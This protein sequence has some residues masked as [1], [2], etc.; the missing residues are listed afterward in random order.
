MNAWLSLFKKDFRIIAPW[1]LTGLL[2]ILSIDLIALLMVADL[3]T[4][5]ILSAV[6]IFFHILY[7][8][9]FLIGSLEREGKQMHL[10]LHSPRPAWQLL[11]SKVL[12]ALTAK[13]LSLGFS[14]VVP[15]WLI[16]KYPILMQ[17]LTKADMDSLVDAAV[18]I[19]AA[20]LNLG[21]LFLLLWT[22]QQSLKR[23]IGKWSGV[24]FVVVILLYNPLMGLKTHV[25]SD[26]AYVEFKVNELG[27]WAGEGL[28][29][30][31]MFLFFLL[32]AWLLDKKTEV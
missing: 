14:L 5:M 17:E 21:F 6:S 8:P 7:F 18:S 28:S 11:L 22:I 31:L 23:W 2:I 1:L 20:S 26:E 25:G 16:W 12:N 10:W 24:I 29:F 15:A 30:T 13:I 27:P 4:K 9:V 19:F 32:S 3:E